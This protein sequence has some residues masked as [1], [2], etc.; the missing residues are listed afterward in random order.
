[1]LYPEDYEDQRPQ[2]GSRFWSWT[3]LGWLFVIALV[4]AALVN[5]AGC[6]TKLEGICAVQPIGQNEQGI[7]FFRYHCEPEN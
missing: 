4:G 3:L 6:A 2:P 5:L 1:M 7:A